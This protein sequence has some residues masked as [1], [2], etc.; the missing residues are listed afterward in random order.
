MGRAW[1][2]INKK[3]KLQGCTQ[4]CELWLKSSCLWFPASDVSRNWTNQWM[5]EIFRGRYL[6]EEAQSW[7]LR[8]HCTTHCATTQPQASEGTGSELL[9]DPRSGNRIVPGTWLRC[10]S[11]E[12]WA[13]KSLSK[14]RPCQDVWPG[15][16]LNRWNNWF[17][18]HS[19]TGRLCKYRP[20]P[21]PAFFLIKVET[22]LTLFSSCFLST[23]V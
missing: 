9:S 17:S 10:G 2:P 1:S 11:G 21:P 12:Q 4:I 23:I 6:Q 18:L 22:T 20:F 14:S 15:S 5:M 19:Q 16:T 7:Q 8:Q 3:P 13:Q